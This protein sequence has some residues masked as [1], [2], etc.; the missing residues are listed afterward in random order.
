[1]IDRTTTTCFCFSVL[2]IVN[3]HTQLHLQDAELGS[4]DWRPEFDQG[5]IQEKTKRKPPT[6]SISLFFK[7]ALLLVP[8][9]RF[10]QL[11][12]SIC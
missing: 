3:V 10:S 12:R 1:M 2:S 5:Q 9:V 4:G 6:G 8:G 7:M 11:E